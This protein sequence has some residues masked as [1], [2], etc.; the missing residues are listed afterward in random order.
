MYFL[1]ILGKILALTFPRRFCYAVAKFIARTH[2]FYSRKDREAVAYNLAPIVR[3]Q[4]RLKECTQK[5]FINFS[6]YLVDFFRHSFLD[7]NFIQRYVKVEGLDYLKAAFSRG[8]GA[9]VLTAH[10]GNYELGGAVT[11]LL[12]YPLS[13][14]ALTHKDQRTNAFF[15]RQRKLTGVK[16][17][18]IGVAARGCFQALKQAEVLALLG[19]KDFS[20]SALKLEMFSCPAYFP[21]G[22]AFFALKTGAEII[23]SFFIR[24]NKYFYRLIFEKPVSADRPGQNSEAAIIKEY[25]SVLEKYVSKYPDQW[26]MFSRYWLKDGDG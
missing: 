8:Q 25:I 14:V 10:L 26:Y 11:A 4:R 13:A 18:P 21:R 20:N 6:Y 22:A 12:G 23:P 15:D 5:V 17:I 7:Q 16:T 3:D 19:D 2:Y 1:F 24:E 9:I